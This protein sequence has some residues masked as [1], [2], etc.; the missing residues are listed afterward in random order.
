[1]KIR[2][3]NFDD[4]SEDCFEIDHVATI[5]TSGSGLRKKA[6]GFRSTSPTNLDA[7]TGGLGADAP[8]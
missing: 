7:G 2:R 1:V 6:P 3:A 8:V 4:V 5:D